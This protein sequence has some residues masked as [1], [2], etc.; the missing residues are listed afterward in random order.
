MLMRRRRSFRAGVACIS[1]PTTVM[2]TVRW[3]NRLQRACSRRHGGADDFIAKSFLSAYLMVARRLGKASGERKAFNA[4]APMLNSFLII[5]DIVANTGSFQRVPPHL[6]ARFQKLLREYHAGLRSWKAAVKDGEVDDHDFLSKAYRIEHNKYHRAFWTSLKDDLKRSP[7]CY[8]RTL[9][10][11]SEVRDGLKDTF[12]QRFERIDDIL[13]I[14]NIKLQLE[15]GVYNTGTLVPLAASVVDAV[16]HTQPPEFA[17][18][19]QQA[20]AAVDTACAGS[21]L[22]FMI[23]L[24]AALRAKCRSHRCADA[25]R[26]RFDE[27][28]AL[29][30]VGIER[31]KRF[32]V[33]AVVHSVNVQKY[34]TIETLMEPGEHNRRVHATAMFLHATDADVTANTAPETFGFDGHQLAFV[35]RDYIYVVDACAVFGSAHRAIP[36][37][38]PRRGAVLEALANLIIDELEDYHALEPGFKRIIDE[39]GVSLS[40]ASMEEIFHATKLLKKC[41]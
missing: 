19:V 38:E 1:D 33:E 23:E 8:A 9:L 26:I 40:A 36:K 32:I 10:V 3:I 2:R 12:F 7:P 35:R 27:R 24:I 37:S 5:T 22:K 31:T 34:V 41:M 4:A 20:W 18:I 21:T 15:A 25:E 6:S 29:G 39:L 17:T 11:L 30:I 14:C 28:L 13:D 16:T